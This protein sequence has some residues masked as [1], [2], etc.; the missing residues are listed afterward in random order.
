MLIEN[1]NA[2][3]GGVA[4]LIQRLKPL[5]FSSLYRKSIALGTS[6]SPENAFLMDTFVLL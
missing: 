3:V 6:S 4:I 5:A 2:T 1:C